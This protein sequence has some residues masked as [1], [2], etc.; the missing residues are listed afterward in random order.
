[1]SLSRT[2]DPINY[3]LKSIKPV[4]NMPVLPFETDVAGALQKTTKI[5]TNDGTELDAEIEWGEPEKTSGTDPDDQTTWAVTGTV[6]LPE[7]VDNTDEISLEVGTSVTVSGRPSASMPTASVSSGSFIANQVI[8][9]QTNT[10]GGTIYYT[11]DGSDP[12]VEGKI[13]GG[14]EIFF[15]RNDYPDGLTIRAIT[16]K[17]GLKTSVE[18]KYTYEF[19]SDVDIPKG[20]TLPYTGEEQVG[21]SNSSFYT[22]TAESG[23]GAK[24]DS[25]GNAVATD[26]GEY[27][28]TAKINDGFA[29]KTYELTADETLDSEKEYYQKTK[30]SY[31]RVVPDSDSSPAEQG[32]YELKRTT[33]DQSISF[34][35][36]SHKLKKVEKKDATCN[37]E[38]SLREHYVCEICGH[39]FEDENAK[40]EIPSED[41][42]IPID[43]N[44]HS[45][46]YAEETLPTC[47]KNGL[48]THYECSICGAMFEDEAG[49]KS[50]AE[51][52]ITIS[53]TGHD[54][55]EWEETTPATLTE[56]GVETRVCKNDKSHKE[57]R[58][59]PVKG[60]D[61]DQKADDGTSV[62]PGASAACADK[63]I[64]GMEN[65]D[66]PAGSVYSILQFRSTKQTKKAITL[67]W[68][69]PRG[70]SVVIIYGNKCGKKNKMT[71]LVTS[72]G[73]KQKITKVAG[74]K[75]K[76]GTMYKFIL[77]ALDEDGNV[78]STSKVIHVATKG[79]K[80]TNHKAV[81]SQLKKGKKWKNIRTVTVKTGKS[82]TIRG[83]GVK[84][85]K[86]LKYKKH[87][88]ICYESSN[89]S[90]ATVSSKGVIKGKKKGTCYVY[91]YSQ[92]GIA[93]KIKVK[94]K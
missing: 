54:W 27:T 30:E 3:T 85:S 83:V 41:V 1:M 58:T 70:T 72:T 60:S 13:Y 37:E 38:G 4:E 16:K 67:K 89:S 56:T 47:E 76:K 63:A 17:D 92:N 28:V 49:N 23:S 2:F 36:C 81:K 94:V 25:N 65:D 34:T 15:N 87:V 91:A 44:A 57:T 77:V 90:I 80:I 24:I 79:G 10:E 68:K 75:L 53:A 35:I 12:A 86:K 82:K 14:E 32:L 84:Q 73:K 19:A 33:E 69:K 50:I 5:I 11:T 55:G 20:T 66:S 9:L 22:L 74:K 64:T 26:S 18:A 88:A 52:D 45:I 78:I 21:V 40:K 43:K 59:I 51:A 71:K 62:G 61:P 8:T 46:S 31:V 42:V 39:H 29:W 48:K 6:Q 93:K 7:Y